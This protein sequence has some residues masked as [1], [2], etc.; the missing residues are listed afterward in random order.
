MLQPSDEIRAHRVPQS[1]R[2]MVYVSPAVFEFLKSDRH[3]AAESEADFADVI[4]GERFDVA[5]ELDHQYCLMARLDPPSDEVW[6]VRIYDTRPQLRFF[7]RFV[8]C[9]VFVTLIGPVGRIGKTLRWN[10][11]KNK[12]ISEWNTLFTYPPVRGDDINAYLT[13][14]DLV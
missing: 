3:L 8:A 13:N 7:G 11:I 6:E 9:N 4:L 10:Q 12:C 1:A 5:L 2:R 14:V